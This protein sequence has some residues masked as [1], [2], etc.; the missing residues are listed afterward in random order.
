[1]TILTLLLIAAPTAG[2][3][4]A[5]RATPPTAAE[6]TQAKATIEGVLGKELAAAKMP[7]EKATL[8]KRLFELGRDTKERPERFV[9]WR[10]ACEL[11]AEGGD[12]A[13]ALAAA[14]ALAA[15]FVVEPAPIKLHIFKLTDPLPRTPQEQKTH[16]D[17]LRAAVEEAQAADAFAS[18]GPLADLWIAAARKAKSVEATRIAQEKKQQIEAQTKAFGEVEAALQTLA[19]TPADPAANLAAGRYFALQKRDWAR[20]L[21]LLVRGSDEKLKS[22]AAADQAAPATAAD[23]VALADQWWT[24]AEAEDDAASKPALLAR[25]GFWYRSALPELVGLVKTKAELRLAR[26]GPEVDKPETRPGAKRGREPLLAFTFDKPTLRATPG[27]VQLTGVLSRDGKKS[28]YV[29]SATGVGLTAGRRGEAL[30]FERQGSYVDFPQIDFGKQFTIALWVRPQAKQDIR[31]ILANKR[32]GAEENGFAFN[33]NAWLTGDRAFRADIGDGTR[34]V[35][36][37]G[38]ATGAIADEQW[39][40]LAAVVDQTKG[41]LLLY[42]DGKELTGGMPLRGTFRTQ[43]NWRLGD[44]LI[45]PKFGFRGEMDDL[46]IFDAALGPEE[47]KELAAQ[48]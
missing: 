8:A 7:R 18:A 43:N 37:G 38:S 36:D 45:E 46:L 17:L 34:R 42:R 12:L 32:S 47:I 22:V 39:Q 14:D 31:A 25:A 13:T 9:V 21:P 30:K 33:L 5:D 20:G 41:Q 44:Y 11:G 29:G 4:L 16:L 19:A 6:Q 2:L 27:G 23:K 28:D 26:I 35:A 3:A 24:L 15:D 10:M 40:H 48:R 1:M